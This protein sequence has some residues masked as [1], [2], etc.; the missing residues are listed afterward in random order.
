MLDLIRSSVSWSRTATYTRLS[1]DDSVSMA[2][3]RLPLQVL[4]YQHA[5]LAISDN[6]LESTSHRI[7]I[8]STLKV[9]SEGCGCCSVS[10]KEVFVLGAE[11]FYEYYMTL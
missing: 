3:I 6:N 11:I 10:T 5:D 7:V 1:T 8:L 2:S 4:G 9:W